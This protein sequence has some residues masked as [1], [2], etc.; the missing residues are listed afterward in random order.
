LGIA[1]RIVILGSGIIGVIGVI[2]AGYL[3][4]A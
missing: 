2:N 1:M 4:K 3:A